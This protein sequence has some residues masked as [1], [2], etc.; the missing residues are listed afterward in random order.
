MNARR[1]FTS[2]FVLLTLALA[3]CHGGGGGEGPE[4]AAAAREAALAPRDVRLVAAEVEEDRPFLE[5]VGEVRAFDTVSVSP[6]VAGTID[7]VS[8]EVGD[9]VRAGQ[10][11]AEVDRS[12][13]KIYLQQAEANLAAAQADLDLADKGLE[14]KRD[15]LSD[16]TIAQA[17]YDQA[18]A[19]YDLAA[20]RV[21][22]AEAARDLAMRNWEKSVVRAPAAGSITKRHVVA[23]QWNDVGQTIFELAIGDTV[24][25]AAR[26]PASWAP[27]LS[28]L[29]GFDF[30][31]GASPTLYRAQLHS[32]DPV[33]SETSRSFEVVGVAK[34]TNGALRP[35]MF[36][37]VT[38][39]A[40]ESKRSL[41][42][43]VSAVS[44]SDMSQ[45]MIVSDGVV[46]V[47]R[48]QVGRRVDGRVEI[49]DGLEVGQ[50]VI[51]DTAGLHRG[52][53]V[54]IVED[55]KNS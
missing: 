49:V 25:V 35:G 45:V 40:P 19:G 20:A 29:D 7:T 55:T 39:E 44:T 41:W 54:R 42:L 4:E 10:P 5:L 47:H 23:G 21:L 22:G 48:V 2:A 27:R 36:A 31:V 13:F 33:V 46:T 52:V 32:V 16:D 3:G 18:K 50:P 15:L 28:G 1:Q 30:T 14:R 51:A 38:L 11:L 8:V 43:P 17:T 34:N 9:H 53:P 37:N 26:V 12:T 24:K 6:E